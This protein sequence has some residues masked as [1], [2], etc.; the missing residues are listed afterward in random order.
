MRSSSAAPRNMPKNALGGHRVSSTHVALSAD[1]TAFSF[2][3]AVKRAGDQ[4]ELRS[5]FGA[6][7]R[8]AGDADW[9]A[10]AL[11]Q[12]PSYANRINE[13]IRGDE[14][15]KIQLEWLAPLLDDQS[16]A[17]MLL[18]WL[19]NRCGY[20]PP[21]RAKRDVPIEDINAAAREVLAEIKD[22]EQ[23]DLMKKRIAK[24]L[25]VRVEDVRL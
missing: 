10:T 15:R 13:A 21:V 22:E 9:L 14:D 4:S 11:D 23:R 24:K 6:M 1:Q 12:K 16:A 7:V 5:L 20:E 8:A 25:G 19:S 18:T 17:E 3:A 2:D